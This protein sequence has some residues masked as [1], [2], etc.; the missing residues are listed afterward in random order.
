MFARIVERHLLSAEE[1]LSENEALV[2]RAPIPT[3][4]ELSGRAV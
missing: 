4:P 2:K 3:I 1:W